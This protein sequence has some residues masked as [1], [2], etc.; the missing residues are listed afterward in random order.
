[1]D[2]EPMTYAHCDRSGRISF[3]SNGNEPGLLQIGSGGRGFRLKVTA[4]A[5]HS[6]GGE[7]LVPGV[8]EA[9]IVAAALFAAAFFRDWLLDT[10]MAE[11]MKR[12]DIEG[13]RNRALSRGRGVI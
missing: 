9:V 10:P 8:P 7:L 2:R 12:H 1:M 3:T 13:V 4:R 5:R 11:L 6:Y